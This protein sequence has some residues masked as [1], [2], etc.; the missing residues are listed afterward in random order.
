MKIENVA[1]IS[2]EDYAEF[3]EFKKLKN[4]IDYNK[5]KTG[6]VVKLNL[7]KKKDLTPVT[8][9]LYNSNKNYTLILL[10]SNIQVD[11]NGVYKTYSCNYTT[12]V[13]EYGNFIHIIDFNKK[14]VSEVIEY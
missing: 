3:M 11:K 10:N 6:S 5:L 7:D 14:H 9:D 2:L 1:V 8:C 12:I 4:S 13:D